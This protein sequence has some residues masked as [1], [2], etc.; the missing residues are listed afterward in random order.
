M[1]TRPFARVVLRPTKPEMMVEPT[2][3]IRQGRPFLAAVRL[4][5]PSN[6]TPL[7]GTFIP[8]LVLIGA[9]LVLAPTEARAQNFFERLFGIRLP[10]LVPAQPAP[11]RSTTPSVARPP[12]VPSPSQ[13]PPPRSSAVAVP[14]EDGVLG[15]ELKLNG[16]AGSLRIE[17]AGPGLLQARITLAGTRVRQPA[18]ACTVQLGQDAPLTVVPEGKTDGVPRYQV[19]NSACPIQFD[20]LHEAVLVTSPV[21]GCVVEAAGC[22]AEVTGLWGPEPGSLLPKAKEIEQARGVADRAVQ[23]GYR[24]LTKQARPDEIRGIVAEQASFSSSREQ[25]CRSYAREAGHGFCNARFTEARALLVS[26]RLGLNS[27]SQ[28][29]AQEGPSGPGSAQASDAGSPRLQ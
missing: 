18:E 11:N 28:A 26:S 9:L 25:V 23:E 22:R 8:R 24:A 19:Q 13:P 20:V 16:N 4:R 5:P 21:E 7:A 29:K 27:A 17:R 15:A 1:W 3:M 6:R 2:T 12:G 14:S 10:P